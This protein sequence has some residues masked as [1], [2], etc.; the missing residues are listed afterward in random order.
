RIELYATMVAGRL[1]MSGDSIDNK[2][3]VCDRIRENI[4]KTKKRIRSVKELAKIV[5]TSILQTFWRSMNT[6]ITT[7]IAVLE[8]LFLGAEPIDPFAIALA[9]GLIAGTYSS[10]F[11]ASQL[12]LAWR[13]RKIKEKPVSFIKKKRVEGTQV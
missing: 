2:I 5:N 11:L 9:I 12:W 7:M 6:A 1:T 10:L 13:G 4:R 3:V 8:F